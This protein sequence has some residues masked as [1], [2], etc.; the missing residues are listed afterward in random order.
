MATMIEIACQV[1]GVVFLAREYDGHTKK[2]CSKECQNE[3]RKITPDRFWSFIDRSSGDDDCWIWMKSVDKNGYGKARFNGISG[4]A[5]RFAWMI[6]NNQDVPKDLVVR[7]TCDVP[8]CCNPAHLLLGTIADNTKDMDER[9]RRRPGARR[10]ENS[11][12]AKL[13]SIQVRAIRNDPRIQKAIAEDYGV[14]IEAINH[15]KLGRNWKH[16]LK[17]EEEFM[18]PDFSEQGENSQKKPSADRRSNRITLV[19]QNCSS[20]FSVI[21]WR[22]HAKYCSVSCRASAKSRTFDIIWNYIEA[23]SDDECWPWIG[24]TKLPSG[25]GI[26]QIA[27]KK[28]RAHRVAWSIANGVDVRT[29]P[30]DIFIMHACDN[31]SC[32][33]PSH[34]SSGT[35]L[36][37]IRD[38]DRKGRRVTNNPC[39][40]QASLAK[41]TEEQVL[42]IRSDPRR[43]TEIAKDYGIHQTNVSCIKNR[44]TWKHLPD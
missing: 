23:K 18:P 16:L 27:G 33:N 20:E 7:H 29:L 39:G 19:C 38:M 1:C 9:G 15:I 8:S 42:K 41:L 22:K 26:I 6:A 11:P 32:C 28:W 36:E 13:N 43:T 5:H 25:Y 37:N 3:G 31:P 2:Y 24:G 21:A 30:E 35:R 40:E 10:G 44:K 34:L 14:S 4:R 12:K 17:G